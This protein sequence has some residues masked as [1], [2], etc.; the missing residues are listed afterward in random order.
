MSVFSCHA[1]ETIAMGEGGVVTTRHLEVAR[2]LERLRNHAM[3]RDESELVGGELAFAKCGTQNPWYYEI[4]ELGFNYRA[5]DIHCAL[6][7]SQL[8]KL[9]RFVERRRRLAAHYDARLT[10]LGPA[11]RPVRM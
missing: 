11:V 7:L 3:I 10:P 9:E 6:G 8:E 5:S 1:V 2:R 4:H